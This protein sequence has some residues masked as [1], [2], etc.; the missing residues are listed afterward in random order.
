MPILLPLT[1]T[2]L[3]AFVAVNYGDF[4]YLVI[5]RYSRDYAKR[6]SECQAPTILT[7]AVFSKCPLRS[8]KIRDPGVVRDSLKRADKVHL[9]SD[10]NLGCVFQSMQ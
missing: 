5:L 6:V 7:M 4:F 8:K 2:P 3:L 9:V 1:P 10:T